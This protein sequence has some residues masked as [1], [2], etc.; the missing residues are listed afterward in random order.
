[1]ERE[2]KESRIPALPRPRR[3]PAEL[4]GKA[5]PVLLFSLCFFAGSALAQQKSGA[6]SP[7]LQRGKILTT[8]VTRPGVKVRGGKAEILLD[9]P[10]KKVMSVV[11]DYDN[12]NKFLPFFRVSRTLAKRGGN[13]I[14][15]M[16]AKILNGAHTIWVEVTFRE[17]DSKQTS[18]VIEGKMNRG[19]VN[20]LS[21][22]WKAAAVEGNKTL[23]SFEFLVD[24]DL[25]LPNSVISEQN[26]VSARRTVRALRKRLYG[27]LG[28]AG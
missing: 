4:F 19:N 7:E 10:L 17:R 15:Y 11:Q 22:R 5:A 25:P 6:V 16:E 26:A 21:L 14:A 1:M 2:K 12:Y 13:A 24:P 3:T 20:L 8:A 28:K 23:L 18:K 9:A 27:M